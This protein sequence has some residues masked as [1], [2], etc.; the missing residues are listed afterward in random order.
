MVS[1][2]PGKTEFELRIYHKNFS[3]NGQPSEKLC[4][5]YRR[6]RK[7]CSW[8]ADNLGYQCG[9]WTIEWQGDTGGTT[10]G[11]TIL[12]AVKAAVDPSTSVVFAENPDADFV[13]NGGFSYAI[14]VVGEHPYTETPR[15][16]STPPALRA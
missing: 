4:P 15:L 1:E 12:D 10:I 2:N 14:V 3:R 13:K 9:G 8:E 16:P 7:L 5:F 6:Y 11:T